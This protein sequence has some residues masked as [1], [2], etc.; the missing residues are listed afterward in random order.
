[1]SLQDCQN[2]VEYNAK[3][4]FS[5]FLPLSL[6]H[7]HLHTDTD[8]ERNLNFIRANI[9]FNNYLFCGAR[10]KKYK[11]QRNRWKNNYD[12]CFLLVGFFQKLFNSVKR[13]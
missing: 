9:N 13:S 11:D 7:T 10:G 12:K 3:H 1:M 2:V 4:N 5:L 6:F 8:S